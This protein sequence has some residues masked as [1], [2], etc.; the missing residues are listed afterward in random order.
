[1]VAWASERG[2][3]I[4]STLEM[5]AS[6][7]KRDHS[8]LGDWTPLRPSRKSTRQSSRTRTTCATWPSSDV[9]KESLSTGASPAP[10]SVLRTN[11]LPP[12]MIFRLRR[13]S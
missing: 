5:E 1:M 10:A 3:S 6:A 8:K 13:A 7:S 4:I 9:T 2:K 11:V 12:W